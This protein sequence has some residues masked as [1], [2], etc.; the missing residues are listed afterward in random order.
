ME[1]LL[2]W[3]QKWATL[4]NALLALAGFGLNA[5]VLAFLDKPLMDLADGRPK[6]D[7]RFGYDLA[8]I[9]TLFEAYGEQGRMI[10]VWNLAADMFLPLFGAAAGVLWA[11]LVV[12]NTAWQKA[13][14][15]P[16][17]VFGVTDLIENALLF[18]IVGVYPSLPPALIAF[19]SVITQVK[20][21]AYYVSALEVIACALALFFLLLAK[22]RPAPFAVRRTSGSETWPSVM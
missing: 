1:R 3:F 8:Y 10:Y 16:P 11:L 2:L 14:A 12:R 7:L 18:V 22:R 9:Q 13:L 17:L 5:L 6:P 15:I 4:K 21:S 19:T 20:R